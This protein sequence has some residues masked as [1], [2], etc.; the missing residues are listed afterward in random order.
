MILQVILALF[1]TC[2]SCLDLQAGDG[3]VLKVPDNPLTPQGLMTPYILMGANCNEANPANSRFVHGVVLNNETGQLFIYNPLVVTQ[4]MQVVSNPAPVNFTLNNH[5]VGL[6]IG[7]NS[8]FLTLANDNGVAAG[9]CVTGPQG[10]PFGQFA[11][12][13]ADRFWQAANILINQ[14]KIVVPPLTNAV[15]GQPC[16]TLRDFFIVDMDPDDGVQTLYLVTTLNHVV[17]ITQNN[18]KMFQ[19]KAT[20][21]NDGDNL[22]LTKFVNP[23][24]GCPTLLLPDAADPGMNRPSDVM[25]M[26]QAMLYQNPPVALTP[27]NDPM[28]TTNGQPD[29]LK[30][31]LYR[32]GV[33]QPQ[34]AVFG[35]DNDPTAYCRNYANIAVPRFKSLINQLK[36]FASPAPTS[37]TLF[38]FMKTRAM[39]TWASL[40]C[41][42]LTGIPDP[43]AAIM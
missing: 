35:G 40:N 18:M 30:L 2:V 31:N 9:R 8:N 43:F 36:N 22:L 6:W 10:S 11:W 28:I 37:P 38:A 41:Q 27:S 17:Q 7:S 1:F 32:L 20:L 25:N 16:P 4:G 15:D 3:C 21:A 12:C 29:L 5:I 13:N 34:S 24:I 23:A 33:D 14:G 26:I 42:G 19:I 39:T